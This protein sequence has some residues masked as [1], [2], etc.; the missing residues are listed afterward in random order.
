[1]KKS[2]SDSL[3]KSLAAEQKAVQA[4]QTSVNNR[5]A[6]AE[7]AFEEIKETRK[8]STQKKERIIK[9]TFTMPESDYVLLEKCKDRALDYRIVMNKSEAIRA[10]LIQLNN[11][12]GENFIKAI[13]LVKKV[14]IGRPKLYEQSESR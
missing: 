11:L 1:M 2:F 8:P 14:H 12:S 9:D 4:K 5:I 3:K 10:G 6:K 7:L 13:K